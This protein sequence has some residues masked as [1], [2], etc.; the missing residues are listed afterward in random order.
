M[1][2]I[3][4]MAGESSRFYNAGYTVPKYMLPLGNETLFDK[5][6]R[7]FEKY[8]KNAYFIFVLRSDDVD[9][10]DF[11][12]DH[13]TLLGI[14]LFEIVILNTH[15]RGQAETVRTAISESTKSFTNFDS[16]VIFNIDT[17]RH[18]LEIPVGNFS[19]YFDAFYDPS[20]DERKWSFCK[21]YDET[22]E[23]PCICETAEKKR[24]SDWCSTGLYIFGTVLQFCRAYEEMTLHH[25]ETYNY[26]IAPLYNMLVSPSKSSNYLM[27][28]PIKD[29]EFAGTPEDYEKLKIKYETE[30]K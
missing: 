26:Y 24:I 22:A 1:H 17:I 25:K 27:K 20:A 11:V 23:K 18:N 19:S 6:V 28:C 9:G 10:Y 16:L 7:T 2:I 8:F 29:V 30:E 21:I 12:N 4:P 13:A 14:E 3:I 15:T 5:S